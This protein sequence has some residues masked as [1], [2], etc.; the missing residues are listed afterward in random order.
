[1][2]IQRSWTEARRRALESWVVDVKPILSLSDWTLHFNYDGNE[3][4]N[5][6]EPEAFATM[7]PFTDSRHAILSLSRALLHED[8]KMQMQVLTHELC[9]CYF[10]GITRFADT[11]FEAAA[12][13]NKLA[14]KIF[15]TGMEQQVEQAVDTLAD[16]L[17]PL[18]PPLDL[19]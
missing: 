10:F 7:S 2:T 12:D 8:P 4:L 18:L 15:H 13:E 1:M 3:R 14:V 17:H 6:A 11:S 5:G 16:A 19:T 9:H